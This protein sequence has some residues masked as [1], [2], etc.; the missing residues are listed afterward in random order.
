MP[1]SPEQRLVFA[2]DYPDL[3][4]AREAAAL[5]APSVGVLK[6]CVS[7]TGSG[8]EGEQ[9]HNASCMSSDCIRAGNGPFERG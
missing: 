3:D 8:E 2:L 9:P 1:P 7:E 6:V 5:L 4:R